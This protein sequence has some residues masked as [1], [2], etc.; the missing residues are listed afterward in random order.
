MKAHGHSR[1]DKSSCEYGCCTTKSDP[2][3]NCRPI[4][5]RARR[6]T[7]RQ[8]DKKA[9]EQGVDLINEDFSM[10]M[11]D[12]VIQEQMDLPMLAYLAIR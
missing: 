7:A 8:H 4:V 11:E 12:L 1:H 5:D 10:A 9:V 3:K 2:K 6:K